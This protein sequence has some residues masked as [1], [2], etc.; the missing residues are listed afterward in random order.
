MILSN[1]MSHHV[2]PVRDTQDLET[3]RNLFREYVDWLGIDLA[4]QGFAEE[5]AQ[6]P[7]KYA[8]PLG[9]LLL[10]S[11]PAGEALGCVGLRPLTIPGACEL[12]RLYVRPAA[13]G[14]GIGRAL[15]M[16]ALELA[17]LRGYR[18]VML[19]TLPS[20]ASAIALYRALGF[21]P[22]PP[23]WDNLVPGALYFGKQL[24]I[25]PIVP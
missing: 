1:H 24:C 7:G 21:E 10:A 11:S 16:S 4:F 22:I 5:L 20:M 2:R 17:S 23:Y 3:V 15:A 25:G 18:Q 9:D 14:L 12:K 6:L 8:P 13:R 19:D